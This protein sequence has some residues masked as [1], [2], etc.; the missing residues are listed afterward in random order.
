[1]AAPVQLAALA[2]RSM[3][4]GTETLCMRRCRYN[5][6]AIHQYVISCIIRR[7]LS[8]NQSIV[9]VLSGARMSL[10]GDDASE[11]QIRG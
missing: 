8:I 5:E 2:D 3:I 9:V 7:H 6:V 10:R 4:D 1:M 11:F